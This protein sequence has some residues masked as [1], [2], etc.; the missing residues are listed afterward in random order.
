MPMTPFMGVRIS[1][2]MLARNALL[3]S[4]AACASTASW[5][6][7]LMECSSSRLAAS[8]LSLAMRSSASAFL[9]SVMSRAKTK[10]Y[11][12]PPYST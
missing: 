2:L 4:L 12:L 11:S 8:A 7:R 9:R 6:V 10:S 1:W 3:A 5:L